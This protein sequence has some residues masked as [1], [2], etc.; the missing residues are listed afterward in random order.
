MR[1]L[2][3]MLLAAA[4]I[5]WTG[6]AFADA[7]ADVIAAWDAMVKARSYSTN[8][9]T[10]A[11]DQV[12]TQTVDVIFPDSTRIVGGPLGDVVVTPEGAW[13]KAPGKEWAVAPDYIGTMTRQFMGKAFLDQAKAGVTE[14]KALPDSTL[15]GRA[16]K[17]YQVEQTITVMGIQSESS[18]RL[19]VDASSGRPVRQEIDSVAMGK[20]SKVVQDISYVPDL[21]IESPL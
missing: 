4:G 7:K 12:I 18:T 1:I 6:Q 9:V 16:V 2:S 3:A 17:V 5:F 14:A 13:Q 8:V 15:G 20:S 10:T 21:K 11:G 19:Y